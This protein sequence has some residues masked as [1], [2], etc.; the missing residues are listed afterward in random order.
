MKTIKT[1][2]LS[3]IM[4]NISFAQTNF[5]ELNTFITGGNYSLAKEFITKL[6]YSNQLDDKERL[7]LSFEAEKLERIKKDFK[8]SLDDILPVIRKY[9]PD[10]NDDMIQKWEKEKSLEYLIIDGEK[11]YFNNAA[12]NLFRIDKEAKKRKL[13]VDGVRQDELKTFLQEHLPI[14]IQKIKAEG[15]KI[16]NPV[17]IKFNYTLTVDTESVPAGE[18]IRCWLPFPREG[19]ERQT[20]IKLLSVNSDEYII[21]DNRH[22]QRTLY[23]EKIAE[24]GKPTTFQL[25]VEYISHSEWHNIN[26]DDIKAYDINSSV[27]KNYTRE[28]APHIVFTDEIMQLSKKIIG[29]EVNPYNKLKRIFEWIY[30]N[31]PWASARE[32]STLENI[33]QYCITNMHGDCGIKALLLITLARFNGIPAKW[34]SGWMMHPN[35]VNLHD[36]AEVYFEGYGWVPVDPDFGIQNSDNPEIK[37]FYTNGIDSYRLIVNDDYSQPLFPAKMYPR[38][39]TVDFQRGEAEWRGGNLYFDKWDYNMEVE[40]S[41]PSN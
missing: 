14:S 22:L 30:N 24:Q 36:W 28:R 1:F 16:G 34:Q 27:Y 21:A 20:E 40:Y 35:K 26:P 37:Y 4:M 25:S 6:I 17:K 3:V 15:K 11:K 12:A 10:V 5:P 29:D 31:I 39:E 32:Y 18:I 9:F 33:P 23:L 19:H 41:I 38:S 13:E 7:A 2:F 8:K